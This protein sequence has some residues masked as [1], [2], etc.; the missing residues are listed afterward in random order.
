MRHRFPGLLPKLCQTP[1]AQNCK[2]ER[3]TRWNTSLLSGS[4]HDGHS[5]QSFITNGRSTCPQPYLGTPHKTT[6]PYQR[7]PTLAAAR[8]KAGTAVTLHGEFPTP[9]LPSPLGGRSMLFW[10]PRPRLPRRREQFQ[11]LGEAA[12]HS[13]DCAPLPVSRPK[14]AAQSGLPLVSALNGSRPC[15]R[16]WASESV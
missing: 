3:P 5:I 12:S 15:G 4:C 1:G 2:G 9:V 14:A 11:A 13:G 16:V 7:P 10:Q 6:R 8:A